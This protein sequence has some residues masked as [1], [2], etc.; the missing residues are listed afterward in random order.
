MPHTETDPAA[1]AVLL[2]PCTWNIEEYGTDLP[3]VDQQHQRLFKI[4]HHLI[5]VTHDFVVGAG[6][7]EASALDRAALPIARELK[8]YTRYHFA[9]EEQHFGATAYP[10]KD[11]HVAK[12]RAFEQ[13]VD[14]LIAQLTDK[15]CPPGPPCPCP[16][17]GG[18]G[19]S[20]AEQLSISGGGGDRGGATPLPRTP[21]L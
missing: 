16:F 9:E 19:Q 13:W 21:I 12:H 8:E 11:A 5:Q 6:D 15:A 2:T 18:G 10:G 4:I 14:K 7:T 17:G 3:E 1:F 20:F